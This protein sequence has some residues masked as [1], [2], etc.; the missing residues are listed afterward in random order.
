M[1]VSLFP[2]SS[3]ILPDPFSHRPQEFHHRQTKPRTGRFVSS[4]FKIFLC[5]CMFCMFCVYCCFCR[6]IF[7][8]LPF[9]TRWFP[10]KVFLLPNCHNPGMETRAHRTQEVGLV[11][12]VFF[13]FLT[14]SFS[15]S[16]FFLFLF[17]FL[18]LFLFL[19]LFLFFSFPYSSLF[20][21]FRLFDFFVL[22]FFGFFFFFFFFLSFLI[23]FF[24]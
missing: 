1:F 24:Y 16:F 23:Y 6:K 17:L 22:F 14:F 15:F 21:F 13:L 10:E 20:L 3:K 9:L 12:F 4:F 18:I 2:F 19:F 5:V 8:P 7:S 11:F